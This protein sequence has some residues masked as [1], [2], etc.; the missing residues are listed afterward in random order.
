MNSD[1]I[2]QLENLCQAPV[3]SACRAILTEYPEV[4]RG[5]PRADD[6]SDSEGFVSDAE[7]F[8]HPEAVLRVNL[9]VRR[10][11]IL[12][13]DGHEFCWPATFLVIGETGDGDYYCIDTAGGHEGVM[14]FRHHT[15]EFEMVAESMPD[16][17]ELLVECFVEGDAD[18]DGDGDELDEFEE[19]PLVE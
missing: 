15:V 8:D 6:G 10:E 14:Q 5:V 13:P 2:S 3:P 18:S 9:E 11:S 19:L 7:L 4:L 16:F 17:I 12:D 1:A